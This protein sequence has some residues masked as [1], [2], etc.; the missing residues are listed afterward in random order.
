MHT[1]N[2]AG[3]LLNILENGKKHQTHLSCRAV[4]CELLRVDKSNQALLVSI[5]EYHIS[6][7]IP[8]AEGIECTLGHV[9]LDNNY[10]KNISESKLGRKL[11]EV[12]GTVASVITLATGLS[13]LPEVY[14]ALLEKL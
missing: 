11:I 13:Q 12:L 9:F 3:R 5:D 6:G 2:P 7:T 14:Q 1:D 4:W 10:R 8:V